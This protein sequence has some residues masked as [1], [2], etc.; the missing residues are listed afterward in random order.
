VLLVIAVLGAVVLSR[1]FV[2]APGQ[3]VQPGQPV[4]PVQPAL[5][6]EQGE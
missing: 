2:R 3:S 1:R 5:P 4:Q 6:G